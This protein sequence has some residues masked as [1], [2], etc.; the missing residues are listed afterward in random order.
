MPFI[1]GMEPWAPKEPK[2]K[3]EPGN[4]FAKELGLVILA[5]IEAANEKSQEILK[6][7][8]K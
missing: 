5:L 2:E 3:K 8:G 7:I 4:S 6:S 1:E